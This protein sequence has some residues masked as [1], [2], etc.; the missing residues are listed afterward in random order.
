MNCGCI[1]SVLRLPLQGSLAKKPYNPIIGE[2]FHCSWRVPGSE[3]R[4]DV[5]LYYTA[6][7]VSHHPPISAFHFECPQQGLS[8]DASIYT[9]SK[10]NGM[11]ICAVMVGKR[12]FPLHPLLL[13]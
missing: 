3:G 9:K 5:F 6:E 10:F 13:W 7:Q 2:S 11:S 12:E 4:E 8:L 1:C